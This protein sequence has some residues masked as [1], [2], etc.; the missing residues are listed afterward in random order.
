MKNL[1]FIATIF[2][3]TSTVSF[4]QVTVE[5]VDINKL[6]IK[7]CELI[8]FNKS[9]FGKKIIVTVD[10]GQ[11]FSLFKSQLIKGPDGKPVVFNSMIDALNFMEKNGWEY[12]NNFAISSG[13]GSVYHYLLRRKKKTTLRN[14]EDST[15]NK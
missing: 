10:Y 14:K 13:N 1:I 15:F 2:M 6:D 8:G 7:Y 12:V 3:L 9:L 5:G 4:G 11:K